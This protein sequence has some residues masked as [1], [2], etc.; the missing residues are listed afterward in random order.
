[1]VGRK[2]VAG[3]TLLELVVALAIAALILAIVVPNI[4]RRSG[5]L[6]LVEAARSVAAT[7]RLTRSHAITR[8]QSVL[9]IVDVD[10][11]V[12]GPANAGSSGHV[13]H[14]IRLA[15]TTQDSARDGAVGSIRFYPDGSSSGG[16]IVLAQEGRR[17][18]VLVNWL[19]GGVSIHERYDSARR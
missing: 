2:G 13:P 7:L 9:F 12:Y 8:N 10:R 5:R 18:E 19:N 16:S 1:M 3:F 6:E 17:Y 14:G 15:L 11:G 4:S